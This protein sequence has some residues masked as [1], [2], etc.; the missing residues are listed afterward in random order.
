M[1][2]DCRCERTLSS[3]FGI[4]LA[5]NFDIGLVTLYID[6]SLLFTVAQKISSSTPSRRRT[7]GSAGR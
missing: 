5:D 4:N 2:D 6:T 7:S 1:A 3:R